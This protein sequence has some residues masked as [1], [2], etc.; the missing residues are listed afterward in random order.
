M[1]HCVFSLRRFIAAQASNNFFT[2]R[3][4]IVQKAHWKS[5]KSRLVSGKATRRFDSKER[6]KILGAQAMRVNIREMSF[7]SG[8]MDGSIRF[9]IWIYHGTKS[10]G[11]NG[12]KC[13]FTS[14]KTKEDGLFK[15]SSF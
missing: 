15:A 1:P 5:V 2:T 6:D 7:I 3:S 11:P 8:V 10:S 12:L 14:F 9:N 4:R 13:A